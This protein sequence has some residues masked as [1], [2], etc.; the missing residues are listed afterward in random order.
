MSPQLIFLNELPEP[1]NTDPKCFNGWKESPVLA[2]GVKMYLF[3]F[4]R[5]F[6][7]V[8]IIWFFYLFLHA[9]FELIYFHKFFLHIIYLF[10][11][12]NYLNYFFITT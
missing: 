12:V 6:T 11:Y 7:L 3:K 1:R 4:L 2:Q 10:A 5:Q 8:N 9:I